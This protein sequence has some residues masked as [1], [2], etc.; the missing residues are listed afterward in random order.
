MNQLFVEANDV[1]LF[2]DGRAFSPDDA[3]IAK[4]I[5]PPSP[6]PFYGALRS[7]MLSQNEATFAH[8]AAE[9]WQFNVAESVQQEVGA[10]TMLGSLYIRDFS[11]AIDKGMYAERL[12]TVPSDILRAKKTCEYE[13]ACPVHMPDGFLSNVPA[14][15]LV[16]CRPSEMLEYEDTKGFLPQSV[17][18][19]YLDG[20]PPTEVLNVKHLYQSELRTSVQINDD[21]FTAGDGDL[22]T[23]EFVRMNKGVGF[24]LN[25][26]EASSLDTPTGL[27]RLGGE[28]KSARYTVKEA[29][30]LAVDRIKE[31][32]SKN[33]NLFKLILTTPTVFDQGWYEAE[34]M[35][36]EGHLNGCS[37]EFV[38]ASVG[39]YQH[40]GGWDLAAGR[41]KPSRRAVAPGAVYYFKLLG[42]I[43]ALFAKCFGRSISAMRKIVNRDSESLISVPYKRKITSITISALCLKNQMYCFYMLKPVSTLEAV[44]PWEALI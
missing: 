43:D 17:F 9:G 31:Q 27:L 25:V 10:P 29:R 24:Y 32:I 26:N 38:S 18:Q 33:E 19:S 23:V 40:I 20:G 3:Q 7:A 15:Q 4:G 8:R 16:W 1:L 11:L 28:S 5:F 2:R 22:F 44:I 39:R 12:F 21:S 30:P 13:V 42:D 36:R 41:P 34:W 6:V 35:G 37:V 14:Q